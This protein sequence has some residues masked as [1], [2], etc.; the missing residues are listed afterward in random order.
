MHRFA[1]AD[2]CLDTTPLDAWRTLP[3]VM[4]ARWESMR[5][6]LRSFDAVPSSRVAVLG[7]PSPRAAIRLLR[8]RPETRAAAFISPVRGYSD[9]ITALAR[10]LR[11]GTTLLTLDRDPRAS[12]LRARYFDLVIARLQIGRAHV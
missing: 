6:L 9:R 5:E 3:G 8:S 12:L 7:Y 10:R 1:A 2:V 4:T 11:L